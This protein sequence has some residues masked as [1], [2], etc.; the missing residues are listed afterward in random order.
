MFSTEEYVRIED[1]VQNKNNINNLLSWIGLCLLEDDKSS[2]TKPF[3]SPFSFIQKK[4]TEE[5]ILSIRNT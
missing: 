1:L 2:Q 5:L 3:T 4:Q